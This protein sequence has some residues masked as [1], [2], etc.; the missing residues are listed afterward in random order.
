MDFSPDLLSRS[1]ATNEQT[2]SVSWDIGSAVLSG[3]LLEVSAYPKPGLVAP[4]AMGA[5]RDMDLQ[6]FM[7]SSAAIAPALFACARAGLVHK[8]APEAILPIIRAIGRAFD[9]R[10]LHA[11]HGVNT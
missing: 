1:F 4:C 10:L 5:H 6:S 11:T 7:L 2:E 8:G 3:L 9:Q